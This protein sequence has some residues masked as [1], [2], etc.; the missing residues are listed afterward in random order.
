MA[1][2]PAAGRFGL[3]AWQVSRRSPAGLPPVSRRSP[4]IPPRRSRARR[5]RQALRGQR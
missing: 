3:M 2:G 5:A 1:I 4:T